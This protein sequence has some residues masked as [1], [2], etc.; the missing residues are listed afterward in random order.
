MLTSS[1]VIDVTTQETV[2]LF[3][4][5]VLKDDQLIEQHN[6]SAGDTVQVVIRE[7]RVESTVE[8]SI[9]HT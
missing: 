9:S 6:I 3:R 8:T 4:G 5:R 1:Y 2:L 7:R